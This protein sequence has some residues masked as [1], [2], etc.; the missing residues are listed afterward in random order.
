LRDV[1]REEWGFKGFVV[2]DYYAIRELNERPE[3]YGHHLAADGK[4]AA[5]LAVKAGVNI[6]LPEPDCYK[7]LVEL[8]REGRLD[9]SLMDELVSA[10]LEA[11]FRIGLFDDPFVDPETANRVVGSETNRGLALQAARET[12]TLLRND[13]GLAPLDA[14]KIRTLAVIGPNADRELLGG[15][16]GKP[17]RVSTVLDGI[18]E[19]AGSDVRVLYHE[20]CKIT[21]GG[22]WQEDAV[23]PCDPEQ[24]RKSIAEAVQ[25]ARQADA[26]VL[27]IGGNEQTSREAWALNHLGDRAD[28]DRVGRQDELVDAIAAIGK[29]IIAFL[30]NGRPLSVRNLCDKAA[31]IF[32]CWYLG[33]ETGRA[34]AEALFGDVNPGGKL[35]ITVPRSV[36]HIPAYYS[37]KPSA[38]RGYLFGSVEPLFAFGFWLSY[39][40]FRFSPPRLE[41][42]VLRAGE[43]TRMLVDVTNAGRMAGD[44][45]VQMYIR[46]RVSSVTRPVKE[47][48]GFQRI[49]LAPGE[50]KTVALEIT[51]ELLA[52]YTIDMEYKVE[53]GEFDILVGKSSR[54]PDLQKVLLRVEG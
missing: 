44:E 17:G 21:V 47:L 3:L 51:P 4:E 28:L 54:D 46:D 15:Y 42:A 48:K 29:P 39:T 18:R 22:S 41:K 23:V 53:P 8:V 10:M 36:G 35:P 37:F 13:G 38:R 2:S 30:F 1:L 9:E 50:T 25:V 12:I 31:V 45:V 26:V 52:F 5:L 27:A 6:E 20:G 19:R 14:K 34:V 43:S 7:H 33:Q 40:E 11:K 16:S 32:E 49:T 24:D